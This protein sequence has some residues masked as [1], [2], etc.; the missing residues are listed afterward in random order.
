VTSCEESDELAE[1]VALSAE[2]NYEGG[3]QKFDGLWPERVPLQRL[4]LK[5]SQTVVGA[6]VPLS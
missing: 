5:G 1:L 2:L 4:N 6:G 3:A